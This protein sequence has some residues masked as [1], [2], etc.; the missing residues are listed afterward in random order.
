[1]I[2]AIQKML[3]WDNK[4]EAILVGAGALGSA[5]L[6]YKG[7]TKHGLKIV[8]AL[9]NN[10]QVVG[11]TIHGQTIQPLDKLEDLIRRMEIPIGI[12]TVRLWL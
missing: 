8:A 11:K 6:G 4:T 2:I 1:L 12:I 10:P 9:D 3:G 7:F 5:L